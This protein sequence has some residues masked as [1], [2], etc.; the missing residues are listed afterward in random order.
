MFGC[1]HTLIV[2]L[3]RFMYHRYQY[4]IQYT[5]NDFRGRCRSSRKRRRRLHII[6]IKLQQR[7]HHAIIMIKII[8]FENTRAAQGKDQET[9]RDLRDRR[10]KPLVHL[11]LSLSLSP[12]SSSSSPLSTDTHPRPPPSAYP[13]GRNAAKRVYEKD[14]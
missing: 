5:V 1:P 8:I 3:L 12:H 14:R 10:Y 9:K 2:L 13:S 7:G 4:T 6:I 11:S